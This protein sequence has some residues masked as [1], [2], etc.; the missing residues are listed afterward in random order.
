MKRNN[1]HESVSSFHLPNNNNN[2]STFFYLCV[3]KNSRER[4]KFLRQLGIGRQSSYSSLSNTFGM[5][6]DCDLE[7]ENMS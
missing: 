4:Y 3:N 2:N 1:N 5:G 6:M 7:I